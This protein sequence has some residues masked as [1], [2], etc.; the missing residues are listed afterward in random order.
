MSYP[1]IYI[2][3]IPETI[4]ARRLL[5]SRALELHT[6]LS[7][8]RDTQLQLVVLNIPL[9]HEHLD[10]LL[11]RQNVLIAASMYHWP[12]AISIP[13]GM[14]WREK[15]SGTV[16]NLPDGRS[17]LQH[18]AAL[19]NAMRIS[20]KQSW[21]QTQIESQALECMIG[22][23]VAIPELHPDSEVQLDINDHQQRLKLLGL[24]ELPGLAA[25]AGASWQL[26]ESTL[27]AM[28]TEHLHARLWHDGTALLFELARPRFQLR[29]L[30]DDLESCA[31]LPLLEGENIIGRRRAMQPSEYRH[32]IAD[33]L[34]SN[35]HALIYCEDGDQLRLCDMSKNGTWLTI[36][37]EREEYIHHQEHLL[38]VGMKIRVGITRMRLERV[39]T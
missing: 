11:A 15:L 1:R 28:I 31:A 22:A 20:L 12:Q 25:M 2:C 4:S 30:G 24:N 38:Q 19:R 29:L 33:D 26:T 13:Y 36:P 39:E 27:Q 9:G 10:V 35:D 34:V 37:G 14:P 23:V 6:L 18:V 17:P 21:Q 7:N 3:D 5:R 16:L 8:T 32:S